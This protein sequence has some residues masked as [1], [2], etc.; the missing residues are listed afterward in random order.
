MAAFMFDSSPIQ[1]TT[2]QLEIRW[3]FITRQLAAM[4]VYHH[5]AMIETCD[6][7]RMGGCHFLQPGDNRAPG[8]T[9]LI[10]SRED[11]LRR[12]VVPADE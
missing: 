7:A 2:P 9:I 6:A 4:L 10:N 5:R 1:G 3:V 8:K 11:T 12:H